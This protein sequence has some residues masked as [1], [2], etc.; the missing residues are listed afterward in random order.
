ME[1]QHPADGLLETIRDTFNG[2]GFKQ[3]LRDAWDR[4]HGASQPA[5]TDHDKAI[6]QMNDQA[7]AQRTADATKSFIKPDVAADIRKKAA[8]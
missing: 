6:Q 3:T 1:D 5:Q 8:K 7:N 2:T 4:L